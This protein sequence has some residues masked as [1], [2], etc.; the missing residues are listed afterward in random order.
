MPM[1]EAARAFERPLERFRRVVVFA[2]FISDRSA[3]LTD[4]SFGKTSAT[5]GLSTIIFEDSRSRLAYLPRTNGPV[6]SERLYSGRNSFFSVFLA[7][8]IYPPFSFACEAR[9]DDPN[10]FALLGMS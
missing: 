2:S 8:F 10:S 5:S 6:K 4:S 7:F 1:G 3:L 9:A